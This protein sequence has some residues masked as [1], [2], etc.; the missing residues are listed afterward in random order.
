MPKR[1]NPFQRLSTSIMATLYNAS[2][3]DVTE[4]VIKRSK[5]GTPRE[6]DIIITSRKNPDDKVLVECRA[7]KKK[8]NVQWIDELD[9]KSRKL[10]YKKVVAVSSS[11]FSKPAEKEAKE[12]GIETFHLREAEKLDWANWLLKISTLGM[13]VDFE[14]VVKKVNFVTVQ[15]P[16]ALSGIDARDIFLVNLNARKKISLQDY[17]MGFVKDPKVISHIRENNTNNANNHYDY[18]APCDGGLGVVLPDGVFNPLAKIIISFDSVRQNYQ[19]PLK[20]MRGG[21]GKFLVA[22]NPLSKGDTRIVLQEKEGLIK[23]MIESQSPKV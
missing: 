16:L 19:L 15:S 6:I 9:G 22:K 11:G 4:S 8:Q 14:V 21:D 7:W 20:H 12:S 18:E 3:Y 5:V 23:V 17:L 2:D 1:T 13:E 10:G